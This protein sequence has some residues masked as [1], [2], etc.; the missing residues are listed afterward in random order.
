MYIHILDE[1]TC[2]KY[3]SDTSQ[4][5]PYIFQEAHADLPRMLRLP[6]S[7]KGHTADV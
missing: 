4:Y 5:K 3:F 7:K 2:P 6:L 1:L